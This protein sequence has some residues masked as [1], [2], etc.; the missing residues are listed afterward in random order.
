MQVSNKPGS[1]QHI[2]RDEAERFWEKVDKTGSCW[3]W[4]GCNNGTGYGIFGC[5][6]GGKWKMVYAHRWAFEKM[7]GPIPEGLELDHLCRNRSCVNPDHLEPVT[8]RTNTLRGETITAANA[9][10]THCIKGHPLSGRNLT[11]RP[12]GRRRCKAC[13]RDRARKK[14]NLHAVWVSKYFAVTA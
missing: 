9:A 10:K 7:R 2:Q 1:N 5:R 6:R 11:I 13:E 14:R 3:T 4:G 8:A 12:T